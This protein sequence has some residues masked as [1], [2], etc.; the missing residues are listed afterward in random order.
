[1]SATI[2]QFIFYKLNFYLCSTSFLYTSYSPHTSVCEHLNTSA[3]SLHKHMGH[4]RLTY[5]LLSRLDFKI[6][7][8]SHIIPLH[9]F[10]VQTL[11][12]IYKQCYSLGPGFPSHIFIYTSNFLPTY[13]S[14][15]YKNGLV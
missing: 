15:T 13:A 4:L 5:H 8:F 14:E 12:S 11:N 10:L 3:S 6:H 1:M 2:L 7:A 9:S